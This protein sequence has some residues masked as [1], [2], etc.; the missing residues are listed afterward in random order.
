MHNFTPFSAL[1]GGILIGLGASTML[2]LNGKI[3]GISGILAGVLKPFK[4]DTL[5][6]ICFLVPVLRRPRA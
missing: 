4:D 3:A 5:W 2:L 6:R 1:L